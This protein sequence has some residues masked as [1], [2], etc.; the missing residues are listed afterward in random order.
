M[1]DLCDNCPTVSNSAQTDSEDDGT[2]R[3]AFDATPP[4]APW[5]IYYYLIRSSR[6]GRLLTFCHTP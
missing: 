5:K 1:D 4:P 3:T 2:D 6:V